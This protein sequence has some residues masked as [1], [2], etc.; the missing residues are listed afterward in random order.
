[1]DAD[2]TNGL[3][4]VR[5]Y[6]ET[7]LITKENLNETEMEYKK[8]DK[9]LT[10]DSNYNMFEMR[11]G[12]S[13]V[14]KI[15]K[16]IMKLIFLPAIVLMG[17]R[18]NY[19]WKPQ[20]QFMTWYTLGNLLFAWLCMLYTQYV[21]TINGNIIRSLEVFAIYGVGISVYSSLRRFDRKKIKI[22]L[23]FPSAS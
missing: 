23:H 15:F 22:S 2:G 16:E 21:H 10:C 20:H 6:S 14:V 19:N 12:D 9:E 5:E 7:T 13:E 18:V 4:I 17:I 8:S 1:M 3:V 11:N